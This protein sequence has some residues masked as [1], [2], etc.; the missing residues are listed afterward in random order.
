MVYNIL[1]EYLEKARQRAGKFRG[2][3]LQGR[4]SS[5]VSRWNKVISDCD[6]SEDDSDYRRQYRETHAKYVKG[7][8]ILSDS[9]RADV[10]EALACRLAMAHDSY[11]IEKIKYPEDSG[12]MDATVYIIAEL[13]SILISN[14]ERDDN[15]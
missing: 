12:I 2:E 3:D 7:L 15:V 8:I 5:L 14:T 6:S 9:H 10:V 4:A 13:E 1:D 11:F